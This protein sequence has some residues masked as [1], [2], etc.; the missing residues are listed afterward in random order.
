MSLVQLAKKVVPRALY[1]S[2]LLRRNAQWRTGNTVM[3]G[4]FAGMRYLDRS[5][6]GAYIPK[7]IGCYELELHPF[8]E[9]ALASKPGY[10]I[11]IGGAEG[12]YAVG[13]LSR[14]PEARLTVFEQ[15]EDGRGAIAELASINGV[16]SRLSIRGSCDPAALDDCLRETGATFLLSDVEGY[17]LELLHPERVPQLAR[18]N[19]LVEVHDS[20]KPGCA[21]EMARRFEATHRVTRVAQERRDLA[22]Y[23]FDDLARQLAPSWVLRYGLNE[24]RNPVNGWLWLETR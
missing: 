16:A 1:P 8:I 20:A 18:V 3:S 15:L 17:E 14:L 21:E 6:W 4:P 11:D 2:A 23:P 19:M 10:L 12:Y 9:R 22:H 13:L 5:I 24:F 7:L